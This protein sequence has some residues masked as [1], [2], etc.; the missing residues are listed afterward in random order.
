MRNRFKIMLSIIIVLIILFVLVLIS[1]NF[2]TENKE[3]LYKVLDEINNY[4]YT[5][6][7]RDTNIMKDVFNNLKDTLSES[8]IDYE[9]YAEYLSELFI[10]DLFTLNNKDNK[11]DVGGKEYILPEVLDNYI[12]NVE[13]TLYKYIVDINSEDRD[14]L[15]IVS[16]ITKNKIEDTKYTYNDIEYNG[17]I[18]SLSWEYEKDLEYPTEGLVTLIKKDDKL[19]IVSY[20]GVEW[21]WKE[22]SKDYFMLIN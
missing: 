19:Y 18:V 4:K 12:L 17:Y 15:P 6:K 8:E 3:P 14:E 20:E 2:Q 1:L 10:I 16:G 5:L 22:E 9:L 11:Y 7:D 13:D 21:K